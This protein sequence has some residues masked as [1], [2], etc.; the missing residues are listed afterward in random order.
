MCFKGKVRY[1]KDGHIRFCS[2]SRARGFRW[3]NR[4]GGSKFTSFGSNPTG[5]RRSACRELMI[6]E[7]GW[8]NVPKLS[9]QPSKTNLSQSRMEC[10]GFKSSSVTV[11]FFATVGGHIAGARGQCVCGRA[12]QDRRRPRSLT[13]VLPSV[14]EWRLVVGAAVMFPYLMDVRSSFCFLSLFWQHASSPQPL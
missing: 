2:S 6:G 13:Q 12:T 1:S 10:N 8:C 4:N 14:L 11:S 9:K 3:E 7:T 5:S